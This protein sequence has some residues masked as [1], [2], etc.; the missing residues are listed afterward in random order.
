[1]QCKNITSRHNINKQ[2]VNKVKVGDYCVKHSKNPIPFNLKLNTSATKIQ[3]FWKFYIS[4]MNFK[5]QGPARNSYILANN[6]NELYTLELLIANL[7][8]Y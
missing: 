5:R 2:C 3:K 7:D 8:C 1:M 6:L 4:N